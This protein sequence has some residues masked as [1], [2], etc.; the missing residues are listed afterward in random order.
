MQSLKVKTAKQNDYRK[1]LGGVVNIVG[2]SGPPKIQVVNIAG[3]TGD[4]SE[5]E[6]V[7]MAGIRS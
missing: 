5:K 7:S 2:M 6:V 1:C 3:M 4:P